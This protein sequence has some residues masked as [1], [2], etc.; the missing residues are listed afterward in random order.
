ME[1]SSG[2]RSGMSVWAEAG[3]AQHAAMPTQSQIASIIDRPDASF[4]V[5]A[6]AIVHVRHLQ[7]LHKLPS[8]ISSTLVISAISDIGTNLQPTWVAAM[9]IV[10]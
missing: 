8:A 7:H 2:M 10:A 4:Q 6:V 3:Q 1:G 9:R 5:L